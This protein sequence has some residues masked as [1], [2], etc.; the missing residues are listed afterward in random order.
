MRA[1][2]D[3]GYGSPEAPRMR[4][5][6]LLIGILALA[7]F[8]LGAFVVLRAA[9]YRLPV[10]AVIDTGAEITRASGVPVRSPVLKVAVS[11]MVSP[12]DTFESYAGY[13]DYLAREL[14]MESEL[15]VR[16]TYE[17]V[18]ELVENGEVDVA[19]ICTGAYV[20]EGSADRMD[21]LVSPIVR[22]QQYYFSD[23]IV[24]LA[25]TADSLAA[26]EGARFAYVDPLSNTGRNAPR[27]LLEKRGVDPDA[28][29][30]DTILTGSHDKSI[31]AVA[32]GI[33]DG[34]AIDHLILEAMV[35]EG[36]SAGSRVR[37]VERIGPF[38]M[39][40]VVTRLSLDESLRL[41]I[42]NVFLDSGANPEARVFLDALGIDGFRVPSQEEYDAVTTPEALKSVIVRER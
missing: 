11:A 7:L 26:L 1:W 23:I 20:N 37:I 3:G 9:D 30:S 25:S 32:D 5:R 24:P 6:H 39:P 2:H 14:D 38:G 33:V 34:A 10:D 27:R 8:T 15:I 35:L 16:K 29:F 22:G 17:E 36:D 42:L 31:R 21:L 18:N 28:F 13:V 12:R 40:P 19:F 41:R 4:S